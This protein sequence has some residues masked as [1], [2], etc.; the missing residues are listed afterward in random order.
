MRSRPVLIVLVL[1]GGLIPEIALAQDWS[2]RG[3]IE[4]RATGFVQRAPN[5]PTRVVADLLIREEVV[6]RPA[7]WLRFAAGAD[8]RANSHDQVDD[9]WRID[10]GDR[11]R[12]RP[13]V[14]IR[15]ATATISRGP[16]TVDVG[17]QFIR[18]GKTDI[19]NP[20][21]RF[22]PRD[23][24]NVVETEFLAVSG[25]R[26]V[27]QAGAHDAF[28]VVWVP[29]LT[30]SRLPLLDQRW[31]AVP[32]DAPQ[33]R[34]VDAG[35]TVPAGSQAGVRWSRTGS[36]IEYALSF[37]D[38]FNHLPNVDVRAG[39]LPRVEVST[40]YPPIRSY[41]ADASLPTRWFSVKGEVAY[42]TSS[43]PAADQYVIYVV[44]AER[45]TGE[46]SLV[47]GYAGE[48]VTARRAALTFAPDRGMTRS[49][50]GRASY[51]IGPNRSVAVET[52]IRQN[53]NGAYGKAEYSQAHGQHWRVTAA[54]VLIGGEADDF[55]GQYRRNSHGSL[56]LRYSF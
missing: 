49:I 3:F 24:L 48:V 8:L 22:A 11:G 46:W 13:P 12:L 14:S 28:E 27:A 43:S 7:T 47:A 50:V 10:L 29:R 1:A 4:A 9:R 25:V 37:F 33:V 54:G 45:Q 41:G 53:L 17:K 30:T 5:D 52:A 42:V 32:D 31:T 20:T 19:V 44:Q 15:R 56:V 40:V 2:Q 34:L 36:R 38:G 21:D 39:A 51:T 35:A 18:W 26:A 6:A 55:L 16:F 23:F